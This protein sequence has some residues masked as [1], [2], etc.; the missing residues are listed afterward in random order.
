MNSGSSAS[1]HSTSQWCEMSVARTS[2]W[3]QK[4]R[5]G[6]MST[7]AR[8]RE[9]TIIVS[10]VGHSYSAESASAFSGTTRP[11]RMPSSAVMTIFAPQSWMRSRMAAA[12]NPA[13]TIEWIAPILAQ[14]SIAT[15][16]SGIIGR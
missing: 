15:G 3:Y 11:P 7:R 2:S 10:T 13:N 6:S 12:E 8:A 4:S 16:S 1:I 5:P 14:A 9:T